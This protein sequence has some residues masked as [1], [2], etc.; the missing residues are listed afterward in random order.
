[1][2]GLN[3]DRAQAGRLC[4]RPPLG[5]MLMSI[6][7]GGR[8]MALIEIREYIDARSLPSLLVIE[9]T[10]EAAEALGS[11]EFIEVVSTD[12]A[13]VFDFMTWCQTTGNELI[14]RSGDGGTYRF[15]V[16]GACDPRYERR[17]HARL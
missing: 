4:L 7:G 6:G 3:G 1:M 16:R 14:E 11:N 15:V 8:A 13:T 10:A 2:D 12:P 9:Q 17:L 5:G